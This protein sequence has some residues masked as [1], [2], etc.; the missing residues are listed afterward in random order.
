MNLLRQRTTS[1]RFQE[2]Q[3]ECAMHTAKPQQLLVCVARQLRDMNVKTVAG[4]V[5]PHE[6]E[7]ARSKRAINRIHPDCSAL[8][9]RTV[10]WRSY[11]SSIDHGP[12]NL[13]FRPTRPPHCPDQQ[14]IG[15]N[16]TCL[17]FVSGDCT[18]IPRPA[19]HGVVALL[20]PGPSLADRRAIGHLVST[21]SGA[22][23]RER[24]RAPT[25]LHVVE[26]PRQSTSQNLTQTPG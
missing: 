4:R 14:V 22:D 18:R 7:T 9:G 25:P 26:F 3:P 23:H 6:P 11:H 2:L 8:D 13:V 1:A 21:T 5:P 24:R 19:E 20:R 16:P 17:N 12:T 15:Q 10:D